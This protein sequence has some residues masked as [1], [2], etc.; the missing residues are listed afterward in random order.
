MAAQQQPQ[1]G[2]PKPTP[3]T[4][5]DPQELDISDEQVPWLLTGLRLLEDAYLAGQ[6]A[7]LDGLL[8]DGGRHPKPSVADITRS[9]PAAGGALTWLPLRQEMA[10]RHRS[11]GHAW[12]AVRAA[13][14]EIDDRDV[15]ASVV[16]QRPER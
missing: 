6:E 3:T 7:P 10:A 11:V 5:P 12:P 1:K 13:K 15:A 14:P 8:T 4:P 16:D 9:V 2:S